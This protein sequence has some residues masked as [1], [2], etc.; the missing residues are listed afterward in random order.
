M[1]PFYNLF[2]FATSDYWGVGGRKEKKLGNALQI[3]LA[4]EIHMISAASKAAE[5][6]ANENQAETRPGP[7]RWRQWSGLDGAQTVGR[8]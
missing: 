5:R 7:A 2:L 1:S 8:W 3:K 6:E 4:M